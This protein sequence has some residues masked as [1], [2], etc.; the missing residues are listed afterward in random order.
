M[1][2]TNVEKK[3]QTQMFTE[4]REF[5]KNQEAA[6]PEVREYINFLQ[7]RIDL[8][9]NQS[10]RAKERK[11]AKA[12]EKSEDELYAAVAAQLG[13]N[14]KTREDIVAALEVEFPEVSPAKVTNRLTKLVNAG[15]AGKISVNVGE[16]RR[17]M[18]Y[19]LAEYMPAEDE[20]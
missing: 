19:A 12:K 4:I 20:D 6:N 14:L 17:V 5:L 10:I 3:T 13:E 15:V 2:N 1:K 11:Q 7:D 8:L 18:A 9:V 16:G